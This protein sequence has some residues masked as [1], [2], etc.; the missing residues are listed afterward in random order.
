[1]TDFGV[2][3]GAVFFS[4]VKVALERAGGFVAV[5]DPEVAPLAEAYRGAVEISGLPGDSTGFRGL[6]G[7]NRSSV[8]KGGSSS[9]HCAGDTDQCVNFPWPARSVVTNGIFDFFCSF[10]H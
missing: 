4:G 9:G 7:T 5:D 1:M 3:M 2:G 6:P 10:F 8:G